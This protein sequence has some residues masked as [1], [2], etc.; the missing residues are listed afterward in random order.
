[1]RI[2]SSPKGA[3]RLGARQTSIVL[4]LNQPKARTR[5][6]VEPILAITLLVD[7]VRMTL[8]SFARARFS[9]WIPGFGFRYRYQSLQTLLIGFSGG[10][11]TRGAL[12][13]VLLRN[14]LNRT[15]PLTKLTPTIH[16]HAN[17]KMT[18]TLG[19]T[20]SANNIPAKRSATDVA[21]STD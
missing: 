2:A 18:S 19:G 21:K 9:I 13:I 15:V 12:A 5:N 1:M 4:P 20:D 10:R 14:R 16:S 17:G 11:C 7:S 8:V 3:E 6:R